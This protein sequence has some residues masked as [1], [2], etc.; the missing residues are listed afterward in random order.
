LTDWG[1]FWAVPRPGRGELRR[2][3][4]LMGAVLALLGGWGWYRG[5]AGAAVWMGALAGLFAVAGGLGPRTLRP[6]YIPWIY[7]GR[8]LGWINTRLLLGLIFFTLFALT[9][10]IMRLCRRDPLDRKLEPGR[11]SYWSARDQGFSPDQY[12]KQF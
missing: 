8:I 5:D 10:G 1:G 6:V 7:L 4:W 12:R 2:F 9:G 11:D 3:G